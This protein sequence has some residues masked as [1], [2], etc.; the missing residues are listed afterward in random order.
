MSAGW[1]DRETRT[2]GVGAEDAHEVIKELL[3][4]QRSIRCMDEGHFS[5]RLD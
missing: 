2:I 5:K 3:G 4:L 1:P